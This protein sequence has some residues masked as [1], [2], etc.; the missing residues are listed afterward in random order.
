M[1]LALRIFLTLLF[2]MSVTVGLL[3]LDNRSNVPSIVIL[4]ILVSL[5]TKYVLGDWDSGFQFSLLD[6]PYWISILGT[7]YVTVLF[8]QQNLTPLM[9]LDLRYT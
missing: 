8:F 4:P 9:V 2:A 6:V 3:V 7:S 5:L 1:N